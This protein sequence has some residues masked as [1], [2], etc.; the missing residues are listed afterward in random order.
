[1]IMRCAT[2]DEATGLFAERGLPESV[3]ENLY[4][5]EYV[6]HSGNATVTGNFPLNSGEEHPWDAEHAEWDIGYVVDG[7]LTVT[8]SLY[9][10]DDGA[11]ALVV[12]GDLKVVGLHTT[13]DPKIVVA[14]NTTAEVVFGRY[15]DKYLS[16]GGDLRAVVQRWVDECA[17]DFVGG[18]LAGSLFL[19]DYL[20]ESDLGAAHVENSGVPAADLLVPE[21][22]DASGAVDGEALHVRLVAGRPVLLD[23]VR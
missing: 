16:F 3:W 17:P 19:P 21:V 2:W 18:T 14:G 22:L 11:A 4:E 23:G 5:G 15:T 10:V 20:K 13:C 9:D 12:L 7:D 6:L 1:M 8:G